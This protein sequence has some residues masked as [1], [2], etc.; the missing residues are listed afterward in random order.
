[1]KIITVQF[2]YRDTM[3]ERL[4]TAFRNSI[5]LHMP[6]TGL[7]EYTYDFDKTKN[8]V[9]RCYSVVTNTFKLDKWVEILENETENV[10]FSDCD[11]MMVSPIDDVWEYDFDVAYT[12]RR[13]WKETGR[14]IPYNGGVVFARPTKKSLDFFKR[15]A[16]VNREMVNDPAFHAEWRKKYAGMNQSAFGYILEKEKDIC[17]FKALP[18]PIWNSVDE[19]WTELNS[20]TKMVHIKSQLRRC[21]MGTNNTRPQ[22]QR[23]VDLWEWYESLEKN[24]KKI[25]NSITDNNWKEEK[26]IKPTFPLSII[27]PKLNDPHLK[28]KIESHIKSYDQLL[29]FKNV[30]QNY[31]SLIN[32][33]MH[34]DILFINSS[35]FRLI[36]NPI[37]IEL[38][39]KDGDFLYNN[40]NRIEKSSIKIKKS[41]T[42]N[43]V[44]G[45]ILNFRF[46]VDSIK[47]RFKHKIYV[48]KDIDKITLTEH[49]DW[50][51]FISKEKIE[52]YCTTDEYNGAVYK[53]TI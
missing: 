23:V 25:Y 17:N 42:G 29:V 53:I 43:L 5:N 10:C 45:G 30:K 37:Y 8:D 4:L 18:C 24:K 15:W 28:K 20:D 46:F 41:L 14:G 35:N 16:E 36:N 33:A 6:E 47:N 52:N 51:S 2:N 48:G 32:Q 11:M 39:R 19:S 31:K 44:P 26:K 49:F 7:T 1:M 21:C 12:Y 9:D 34:E 3:F 50:K 38:F 22:L 13:K 27:I 40:N